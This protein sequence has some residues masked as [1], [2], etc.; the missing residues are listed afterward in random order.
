MV[1]TDDNLSESTYKIERD[2]LYFLSVHFGDA[3][4]NNGTVELVKNDI[5]TL[6][7][8]T[9]S[10]QRSL[11]FKYLGKFHLYLIFNFGKF[12]LKHNRQI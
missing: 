12:M 7:S 2:G 11:T 8:T 5:T 6:Y 4:A 9:V 10:G 3:E 1:G